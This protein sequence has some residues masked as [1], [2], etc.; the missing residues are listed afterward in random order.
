MFAAALIK[1]RRYWPKHVSGDEIIAHFK[2]KDVGAVD[3]IKG[4][5]DSVP[6]H[7][8]GMKEP[9]YIMMLMTMYGTILRLGEMKKRQY[10]INGVKKMTDFQYPEIVNNHYKYCDMIDNHNSFCMDPISMEETWMTMRWANRVFCFILA[11]T[12]VNIQNAAVYF[13]NKSKLDA[14][15]SRRQ[16]AKQLI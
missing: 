4:T 9:D 13:L 2:D 8:H 11:V 6:F 12:I 5:M 14:L 10:K 16:I 3:A 1:K 15:H 7:I